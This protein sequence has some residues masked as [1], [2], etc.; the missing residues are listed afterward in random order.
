MPDH[1]KHIMMIPKIYL[2][3]HQEPQI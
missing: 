2:I 3:G 1:T